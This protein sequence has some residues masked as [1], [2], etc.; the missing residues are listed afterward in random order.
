MPG[1]MDRA[2]SAAESAKDMAN[3]RMQEV[4]ERNE[5]EKRQKQEIA[6][7]RIDHVRG[8]R[9][10]AYQDAQRTCPLPVDSDRQTLPGKMTLFDDEFLI[11]GQ[12]VGS[13]NVAILTTQ[14][15]ILSHSKGRIMTAGITKKVKDQ[16]IIYLRDIQD[17][18]YHKGRFRGNEIII[19]TAGGHSYEDISTQGFLGW[20]A[21]QWRDNLLKLAH[22]ARQ[23][24]N[25]PHAV[26]QTAAPAVNEGAT[27]PD[28][29]EQLAKLADL[30]EK[31]VLSDAEFEQEKAKLLG[32]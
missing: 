15:L 19:E 7:A 2:K 31:G 18:K 14:R 23:R 22:Y 5:A 26:M 10:A 28:K 8:T 9:E 30:K 4:Q 27:A 1:F 6:Q 20:G 13:K 16:E 12:K 29:Y 25:T 17:V 3:Q 32:N 24:A 21:Q 11:K